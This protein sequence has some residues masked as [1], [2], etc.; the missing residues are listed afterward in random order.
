M[1]GTMRYISAPHVARKKTLSQYRTLHR[2]LYRISRRTIRHSSTR[3]S[4]GRYAMSEPDMACGRTPWQYRISFRTIRHLSALLAGSTTAEVSTAHRIAH[5]YH[6]SLGKYRTSHSTYVA[7]YA[8][9]SS[10]GHGIGQ[11]RTI[12]GG[13]GVLYLLNE[14]M[15]N[16]L[17]QILLYR[18]TVRI[19]QY[20]QMH[21]NIRYL[22]TAQWTVRDCG[23][24]HCIGL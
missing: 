14:D 20:R 3:H 17:L 2:A 24:E 8:S 15:M 1:P 23:T 9:G 5:T 10:T 18:S 7:A 19:S 6:H 22:R 21:R 11:V 12:S 13:G 4:I 16:V